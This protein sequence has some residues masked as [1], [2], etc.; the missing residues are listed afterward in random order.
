VQK[1]PKT[2][3]EALRQ[4]PGAKCRQGA[5]WAHINAATLLQ[6]NLPGELFGKDVGRA[7]SRERFARGEAGNDP[8]DGSVFG[9]A[10]KS[11]SVLRAQNLRCD[12]ANH[13]GLDVDAEGSYFKAESLAEGRDGRFRSSINA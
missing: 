13:D 11:R 8:P 6:Q 1:Q 7:T 12:A 4:K 10:R 3:K 2:Y 5:H 9:V